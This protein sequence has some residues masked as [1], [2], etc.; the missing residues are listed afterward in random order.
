M[1]PSNRKNNASMWAGAA[2]GLC[3]A[4]QAPALA[5]ST[6][7][8]QQANT[9]DQQF[10]TQAI[11]GGNEEIQQARAQLAHTSNPSVRI[12][13]QTMVR[14]HSQ[15]NAEIVAVARTMGLKYPNTPP[16]A[17]QLPR[18]LPDATYMQ[19]EVRDHQQT[20]ALFKGEETNGS[21]QMATVA[22]HIRPI[23]DNHLAMAQQ[24]VRTGRVS[25]EPSPSPGT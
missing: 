22:G 1:K 25:P 23:L 4:F 7:D 13:A 12:F 11:D 16:P 14:D 15:A 8:Q 2:L 5:Q 20:I 18:A 24:F 21:R 17:N 19:N 6:G 10:V 9:A 3:M